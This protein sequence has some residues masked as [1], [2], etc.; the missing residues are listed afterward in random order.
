[1]CHHGLEAEASAMHHRRTCVLEP[2]AVVSRPGQ[3][4]SPRRPSPPYPTQIDTTAG[5]DKPSN[6]HLFDL[7]VPVTDCLP[8][9]HAL[10]KTA[11]HGAA[12]VVS[13]ACMLLVAAPPPCRR[14]PRTGD[15]Q[16]E[17]SRYSPSSPS[18]TPISVRL[19]LL[20]P[21]DSLLPCSGKDGR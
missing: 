18:S 3:V 19:H 5:I 10:V 16:L 11:D 14:T 7:P 13:A 15:L 12:I 6:M 8:D 2:A 4:R 21:A 17:V 9:Q 1:V 20:P